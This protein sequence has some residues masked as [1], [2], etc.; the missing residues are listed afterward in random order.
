MNTTAPTTHKWR[1]A[2]DETPSLHLRCHKGDVRLI[3]DALPGEVVVQ[4][5]ATTAFDPEVIET[6]TEGR[7]VFVNVPAMLNPGDTGFG[8]AVQV[9]RLSWGIGSVN[10]VEIEV[11]LSPDADVDV[12]AE[13]GDLT[14]VGP[15]GRALL[16][17]GGGD[18]R[19]E[20]ATSARVVTQGGDIHADSIDSGEL[21]TGGGDIRVTKL[22]EGTVKTGG[23]DVRIDSI[24]SGRIE[25]GGGDVGVMRAGGDLMVHTG[26]GDVTVLN[27]VAATQVRTGAG[28][29]TVE[30]E[31]GEVTIGT[32]AG[33]I[34]V[35][36]PRGVPVWQDL[37]S[38]FGEVS[39]RIA[40]RGEPQDGQPY[41]RVT[42]RTGTGDVLLQD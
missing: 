6:R 10:R 26:G 5:T 25:T 9:G 41:I 14:C 38:S 24:G 42:A 12:Q 13:G 40:S 37:H 21:R 31:S 30:V 15:S 33:D 28:D 2:T 19:L 39:S 22:G 3:H 18:I 32:G 35:T 1:F 34:R 11:H 4:L 8:F 7:E 20:T 29:V 17:T 36:V 16:Q 23:G 27:C